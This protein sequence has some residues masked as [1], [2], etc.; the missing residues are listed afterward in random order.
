MGIDTNT[1]FARLTDN[2][3]NKERVAQLMGGS[4]NHF[5]PGS[6]PLGQLQHVVTAGQSALQVGQPIGQLQ[7][8]ITA[9]FFTIKK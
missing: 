9:E 4:A 5:T 2:G 7:H 8:A 3:K 6:R 1:F